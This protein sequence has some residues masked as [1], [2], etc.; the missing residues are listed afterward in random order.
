MKLK[1]TMDD[2][3]KEYVKVCKSTKHKRNI[4]LD[5]PESKTKVI[6]E[7]IQIYNDDNGLLK[8]TINEHTNKTKSFTKLETN[9]NRFSDDLNKII[10]K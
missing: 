9:G 2:G 3:H 5:Y 8:P 7:T 1:P 4:K 6:N 10:L